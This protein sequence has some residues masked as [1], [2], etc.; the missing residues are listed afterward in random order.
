M[1]RDSWCAITLVDS[2]YRLLLRRHQDKEEAMLMLVVPSS[3][4][5][6]CHGKHGGD[7]VV[8][9]RLLV[10]SFAR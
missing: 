3:T 5:G 9:A 4:E 1:D 7:G 8:R 10:T 6:G 2:W